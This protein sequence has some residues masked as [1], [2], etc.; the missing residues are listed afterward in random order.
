MSDDRIC[1]LAIVGWYADESD[2]IPDFVRYANDFVQKEKDEQCLN[3]LEKFSD[4]FYFS[5]KL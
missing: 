5:T 1:Y 3:L 4:I 2:D